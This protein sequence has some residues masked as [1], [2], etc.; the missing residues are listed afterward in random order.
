[1]R[2]KFLYWSPFILL[3]FLA[4]IALGGFV[5]QQLWNWLLPAVFGVR[6][7]T[8]WQALGL[9]LLS[10]ILFGSFGVHRSSHRWRHQFAE[11][12]ERMTPEERERCRH[13]LRGKFAPGEP[14]SDAPSD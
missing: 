2:R 1:M 3:A 4:F 12:W 7:V 14:A 13:G 5:V 11:R 6:P 10:R 8:L 9:L